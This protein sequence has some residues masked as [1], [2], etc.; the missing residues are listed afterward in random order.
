MGLILS[1][2]NAAVC[3]LLSFLLVCLVLSPKVHDGVVM[4]IGLSVM[5]VALAFA[6]YF[7]MDPDVTCDGQ[8]FQGAFLLLGIGSVIVIAGY[9]WRTYRAGHP[10]SRRTDWADL[11]SRVHELE[12]P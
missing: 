5:A 9:L 8:R 4:K 7:S 2:T 1:A 12:H 6:G 11:D 10:M 3:G